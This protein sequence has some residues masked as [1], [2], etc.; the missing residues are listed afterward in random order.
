MFSGIVEEAAEV[1][2]L[3]RGQAGGRL[4]IESGLDHT[5]TALGDSIA[6][7]G[8][9]L[10][11]VR[12]NGG[13]LTFDLAEETLRRSTLGSLEQGNKV[14]LERS[15]KL[16]DRIHGHLVYG[17]VDATIRLLSRE[18][19]GDCERLRFELP[20]ALARHVTS[21]CS[22]ALSGISLTVGETERDW[23]SVYIVPHTSQVTTLSGVRVGGAVNFEVDML[24]RYVVSALDRSGGGVSMQLLEEHGFL[25]DTR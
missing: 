18:P 22:V 23:F 11:V 13:E 2:M 5:G 14:N 3:E 17:H 21:K 19:E 1:L 15:L 25:K 12:K 10:T 24:S 8:V 6:I 4:R 9:C 20:A 16:G 7:E